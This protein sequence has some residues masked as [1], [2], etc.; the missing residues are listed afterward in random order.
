MQVEVF[1]DGGRL[2]APVQLD[3]GPVLHPDDLAADKVLALWGRGEPRD[4]VDVAALLI[5]Y[6]G[7]QLLELAER[8][9]GGF[10]DS[11]F[12]EAL[13]GV[14][15]IVPARWAAAGVDTGHATR[16]TEA[17]ERWRDELAAG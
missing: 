1:Q 8:K 14:R 13:S 2:R 7:R 9:D 3:I 6:P 12:V 15:R 11:S 16:L 5:V 10:T 17:M 4:V